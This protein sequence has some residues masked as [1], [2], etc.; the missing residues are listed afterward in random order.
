MC[1]DT[2]PYSVLDAKSTKGSE[3]AEKTL[4]VSG[5]IKQ[6]KLLGFHKGT[7]M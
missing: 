7:A 4:I 1:Q 3:I 2:L 6:R 5:E